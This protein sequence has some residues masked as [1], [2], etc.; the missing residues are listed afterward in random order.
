MEIDGAIDRDAPKQDVESAA[1]AATYDDVS[2][3][4]ML[5]G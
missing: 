4:D 2:D 5:I 3:D 1:A